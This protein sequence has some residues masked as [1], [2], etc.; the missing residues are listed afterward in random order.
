MFLIGTAP[1]ILRNG[2]E[3]GSVWP[4]EFLFTGML[5]FFF[6]FL[7]AWDSPRD[8]GLQVVPPVRAVI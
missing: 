6:F 1:P 4:V 5:F 3:A 2:L 8:S 7:K